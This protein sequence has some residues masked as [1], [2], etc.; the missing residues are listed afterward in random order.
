MII[1]YEFS[2]LV[3]SQRDDHDGVEAELPELVH[4]SLSDSGI[5]VPEDVI[6]IQD[7]WFSEPERHDAEGLR[8]RGTAKVS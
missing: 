8:V 4:D 2:E 1:V 3:R 6:E 7:W 5:E